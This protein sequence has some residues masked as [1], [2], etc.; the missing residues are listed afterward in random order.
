MVQP[1]PGLATLV[2][3]C[4]SLKIKKS[5]AALDLLSQSGSGWESGNHS[6]GIADAKAAAGSKTY[7]C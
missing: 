3:A 5:V 7:Y 4:W 2:G 6:K 1:L